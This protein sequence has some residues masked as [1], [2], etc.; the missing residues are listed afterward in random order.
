MAV[1][2][3]ICGIT[4]VEAADAAVKA[5]ADFAGLVFHRKSP[6]YLDPVHAGII[7]GRLKDR[8]R[9]AALLV[10]PSDEEIAGVA[11]VV[12]PDFLQLHG[13]ETPAR[14]GAV[15]SRFGIPVIKVFAIADAG[16]FANVAAYNDAADMF[17]FDAKA[18]EAATRPGGHGA[19]FDWQ[20]LRGRS[21]A[22]PWLLAGGLNAENV[23]R[24]IRTSE[25]PGVDVS[26]G[27]ET[28]PGAKSPELIRS[29]V[30]AA[31]NTQF[32]GGTD[33]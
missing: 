31:R 32:A 30:E 22:R 7:A 4:S 17:L 23:A 25:A 12:K 26:S 13:S 5:R 29:F 3:K 6:R 33:A 20:L 24:A 10:D 15:K 28:A 8:V 9:T 1:L 2:V 14:V 16:D 27:V 19:A 18:P 11:V 21:F